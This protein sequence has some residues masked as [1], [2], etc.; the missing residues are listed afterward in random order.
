M[1]D[2][3]RVVPSAASRDSRIHT[4]GVAEQ[5]CS[6]ACRCLLNFQP[7]TGSFPEL[8]DGPAHHGLLGHQIRWTH[9]G[10]SSLERVYLYI[11]PRLQ[12]KL[13]VVW[14]FCSTL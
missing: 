1:S 8:S 7:F 9:G 13:R 5:V 14:Q 11:P 3:F 4:A 2:L 12:S 6:S 10:W